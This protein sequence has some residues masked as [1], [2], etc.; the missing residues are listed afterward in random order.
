MPLKE[1]HV[2]PHLPVYKI[3]QCA[4]L[5]LINLFLIFYHNMYWMPTETPIQCSTVYREVMEPATFK[6]T[7]SRFMCFLLSTFYDQIHF[8]SESSTI[9]NNFKNNMTCFSGLS[10]QCSEPFTRRLWGQSLFNAMNTNQCTEQ[11]KMVFKSFQTT[12]RSQPIVRTCQPRSV[13]I[14]GYELVVSAQALLQY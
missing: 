11:I 8:F 1:I 9:Q 10:A 6:L 4:K 13:S 12:M 3:F 14:K 7:G 2:R 5:V